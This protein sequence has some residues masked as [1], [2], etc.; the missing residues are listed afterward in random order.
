MEFSSFGKRFT[1]YTGTRE[2]MDDLGQAM[3]AEER[4]MMLG[5]G[6]PAHIPAVLERFAGRL[7][8]TANQPRELRRMLADYAAPAGELRFREALAA[9]LR[10]EYGWP[11]SA[12]NIALTGGSQ[13][14]FFL[15]F[16]LL[17]GQFDDGTMRRVLLPL[18]PEY[19]G[20]S[21]VGLDDGLFVARRPTIEQL[22]ERQFKYH[23][24]FSQLAIGDD[25]AAICVSRPCNPTGNV[26]TD[27]EVHRLAKLARDAAVPLIIDNAYGMPFPQIVFTAAQPYW[28]DNVILCMS[29]SKIGLPAVRNGIVVARP[30]I[31][32]ALAGMN[33]IVSL[34]VGSV[35]AVLA[36]ELVESG[37]IIDLSR[38]VIRPFYQAR[39]RQA[40]D[41]VRSAFDGQ[42]YFVHRPEGAFFLWLWLPELPITS[43]ELYARL[44][45]RGVY[46]LPG[47]HFFPG[48]E[49][50]WPHRRQCLRLSYAQDP[51]SVRRGI[52]ILGDELRA[53][54][55]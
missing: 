45:Q 6:N 7:R 8:E 20:Y 14:G 19:A 46:V 42:E 15:L 51:D 50:D 38:D 22:E 17:A 52:D 5:G 47:E 29:L 49:D 24:D 9:L 28:D 37:E 3:S 12:E 40:L 11:L 18:T 10:R 30:E 1:R 41:W 33:A 53:L 34:A 36:R 54:E 4:V 32:D 25:I 48:L 39:A 26:L 23:V 16:N 44:K 2:L 21:D 13:S 27:E 55:S 35:G 43:A 31:I